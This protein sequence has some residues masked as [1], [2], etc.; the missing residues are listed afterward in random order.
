MH[1]SSIYYTSLIVSIFVILGIQVSSCVIDS[2]NV[3]YQV[4]MNISVYQEKRT[5]ME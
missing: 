2:K 5:R 3:D 4:H 1:D